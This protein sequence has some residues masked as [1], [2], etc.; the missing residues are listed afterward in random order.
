MTLVL[1]ECEEIVSCKLALT[2][3]ST[4]ENNKN[5]DDVQTKLEDL[6]NLRQEV[7]KMLSF[8]MLTVIANRA[9][10]V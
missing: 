2:N 1:D 6:E 7:K 3:K 10:T 5:L 4:D 9:D 8:R